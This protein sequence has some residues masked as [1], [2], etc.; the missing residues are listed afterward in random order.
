MDGSAAAPAVTLRCKGPTSARTEDRPRLA[1]RSMDEWRIRRR[2]GCTECEKY[3][4]QP[5]GQTN[6]RQKF[7][8]RRINRPAPGAWPTSTSRRANRLLGS[9]VVE[10]QIEQSGFQATHSTAGG[11]KWIENCRLPRTRTWRR[12]AMPRRKLEVV[13]S[14]AR[15]RRPP[16]R[17]RRSNNFIAQFADLV[18]GEFLIRSTEAER[19]GRRRTELRSP[20]LGNPRP[21]S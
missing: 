1:P 3:T 18:S 10:R 2:T 12:H 11:V 17:R 21:T 13:T 6:T 4:T 16:A 7:D 20:F 5:A 15:P 14:P 19:Q 8:S 9:T